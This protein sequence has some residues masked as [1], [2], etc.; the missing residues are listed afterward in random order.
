[1]RFIK[2][3]IDHADIHLLSSDLKIMYCMHRTI[4]MQVENVLKGFHYTLFYL[5]QHC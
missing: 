3:S 4:C 1:M 2:K 5:H